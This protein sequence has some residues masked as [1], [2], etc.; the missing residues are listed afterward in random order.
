MLILLA[1]V[2][3]QTSTAPSTAPDKLFVPN[4]A[5]LEST[6]VSSYV[7]NSTSSSE[8]SLLLDTEYFIPSSISIAAPKNAI[9]S[10]KPRSIPSAAI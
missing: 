7:P 6:T 3:A 2:L 4:Q 8:P 9:P 5:D 10:P 1:L